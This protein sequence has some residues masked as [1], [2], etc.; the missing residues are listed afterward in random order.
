[1]VEAMHGIVLRSIK[2]IVWTTQFILV[3]CD[4]VMTL[5]NQSWLLVDV[6]VVERWR[7]VFILL[8]L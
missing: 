6:Y 5:D 8:N 7:K 4:E 3:S 2:V 1:M